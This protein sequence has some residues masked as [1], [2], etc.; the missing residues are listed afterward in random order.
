MYNFAETEQSIDHSISHNLP[1]SENNSSIL[2]TANLMKVSVFLS[3]TFSQ[4]LTAIPDDEQIAGD[5]SV[6][7]TN[8]IISSEH[9]SMS[10]HSNRNYVTRIH[11]P[12][13]QNDSDLLQAT[14]IMDYNTEIP[15]EQVVDFEN[16]ELIKNY[17]F[18]SQDNYL[19]LTKIPYKN[20]KSDKMY[21]DKVVS[22]VDNHP[23]EAYQSDCS[24]NFC[25]VSLK[26]SN[27]EVNKQKISDKNMNIKIPNEV[28]NENKQSNVVNFLSDAVLTPVITDSVFAESQCHSNLA[29]KK[30]MQNIIVKSKV[31]TRDDQ[32]TIE[33]IEVE[34]NQNVFIQNKIAETID[35]QKETDK[36][37][38]ESNDDI[39]KATFICNGTNKKKLIS[40][41]NN[42]IDSKILHDM[43]EQVSKDLL[44]EN[45]KLLLITQSNSSC[46]Q[47]NDDE[48]TYKNEENTV[49]SSENT[50]KNNNNITE[51][52]TTEYKKTK[53]S[54]AIVIDS[55][56]LHDIDKQVSKEPPLE[57][58]KLVSITQ[59]NFSCTQTNHSEASNKNE[60]NAVNSSEDTCKNNNNKTE[61]DTQDRVTEIA[62]YL[63]KIAK[64]RKK[65]KNKGKKVE[66]VVK[67]NPAIAKSCVQGVE[68]PGGKLVQDEK[69]EL[70]RILKTYKRASIRQQIPRKLAVSETNTT[71]DAFQLINSIDQSD[72]EMN[73]TDVTLLA[74]QN[75]FCICFDFGN[76]AYYDCEILY[77]HIHFWLHNNNECDIETLYSIYNQDYDIL[78]QTVD[79][80]EEDKIEIDT[81]TIQNTLCWNELNTPVNNDRTKSDISDS[82]FSTRM[83]S[84]RKKTK[85][86]PVSKTRFKLSHK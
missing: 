75:K 80:V 66:K 40:L 67:V 18:E 2:E 54:E 64:K 16:C 11:L 36:K 14:S 49:S 71:L 51:I 29:D 56:I 37:V 53:S 38:P 55:K 70:V 60:E 62:S 10:H 52:V 84:A 4:T 17:K 23:D 31:I 30:K 69:V 6:V 44:Q 32:P 15:M 20:N 85:T 13:K 7:N 61:I 21:R 1:D 45:E 26:S 28:A 42:V 34:S 39:K 24:N 57:N 43:S 73:V 5:E 65:I 81:P 63:S 76:L 27:F 8:T 25:G 33:S 72:T 79:F 68:K 48:A 9:G 22:L 77:E 3:P 50:H 19:T 35:M 83:N 47:A 74:R 58:E 46:T 12:G 78:I 82:I 86:I 41:E 59:F